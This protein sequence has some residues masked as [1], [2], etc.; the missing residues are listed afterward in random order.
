[1][2]IAGMATIPERESTLQIVLDSIAP[3]VDLLELALNDY[4]SVPYWLGKYENVLPTLTSNEMGDANKFLRVDDYTNHYYFSC[5]DDIEYP[6]DYVER[7]IKAINSNGCLV[8]V[9][10][11]DIP[12]RKLQSYYS[13]KVMRSH[14]LNQLSKA[15]FV[16]I[17]GSGVSAF[18]TSFLKL[19]YKRFKAANMADI[20]MSMQAHEQGVKRLALKH[21]AGWIKGGLNEGRATIYETHKGKDKIQTEI[22]NGFDWL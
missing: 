16:D 19:R 5:D 15:V 9:H 10:G 17:A 6:S 7:Y 18:H 2:I 22:V 1:M 14:C 21:G 20:W 13:G 11:S 12:N 4:K 3:Q 8:T